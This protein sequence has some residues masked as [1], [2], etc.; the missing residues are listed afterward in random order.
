MTNSLGLHRITKKSVKVTFL[1]YHVT[2]TW[3]HGHYFQNLIKFTQYGSRFVGIVSSSDPTKS[4]V[5]WPSLSRL[6]R[7]G[8][9]TWHQSKNIIITNY[10]YPAVKLHFS[11]QTRLLM[12]QVG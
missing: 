1:P 11:T 9:M 7:A 6:I 2:V 5:D 4:K 3:S 10:W 12:Y 8:S